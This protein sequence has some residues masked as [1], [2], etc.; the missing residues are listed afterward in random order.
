LMTTGMMEVGKEMMV[1][2]RSAL[3]PAYSAR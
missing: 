2:D 1:V 3:A